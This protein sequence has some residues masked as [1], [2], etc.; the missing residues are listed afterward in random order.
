MLERVWRKGNPH[1]PRWWMDKQNVVYKYSGIVLSF[2][3]KGNSDTFYNMDGPWGHY[4]TWNKPL[5]KTNIVGF[6]VY[7]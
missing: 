2:K 4:I 6:H 7:G 1:E 3:K 5:A